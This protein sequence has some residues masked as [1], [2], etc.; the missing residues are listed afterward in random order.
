MHSSGPISVL[1]ETGGNL[2][3]TFTSTQ[4]LSRPYFSICSLAHSALTRVLRLGS[5]GSPVIS[6]TCHSR[7][8]LV[9]A[10]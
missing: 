4:G 5:S 3:N 9:Q 8:S 1:S 6:V 2:P 7:R 10:R